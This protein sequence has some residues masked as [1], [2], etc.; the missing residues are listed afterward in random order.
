MVKN[1]FKKYAPE[2]VLAVVRPI[3][4]GYRGWKK[5]TLTAADRWRLVG[6]DQI[7]DDDYFRKRQLDPWRSEANHIGTVLREEFEP[8]SVIDFGCAI[9][10]HLEPF[11]ENGIEIHGVEGAEKAIEYAVVPP[12]QITRHD[13]RDY[14]STANHYDLALSFEVAEHI[15]EQYAGTFA[16]SLADAS[17]CVVITAAPPG[18]SGTHHVNLQPRSY[19][20]AKF[21]QRGFQYDE[22]QVKTL[23]SQIQVEQTTWISKNI[24]VFRK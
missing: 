22:E 24:F 10:A 12:E 2:P 15:P 13:L 8:N 3:Y 14:Y 5:R 17:D 20:K 23:R 7:Y 4:Q 19:W 11:H 1:A 9:G 18:Q 16:D 6:P 21:R